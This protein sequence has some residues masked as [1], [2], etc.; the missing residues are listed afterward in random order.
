MAKLLF[1]SGKD[2][3]KASRLAAKNELHRIRQG[4]YIDTHDPAEIAKTLDNSW[5][6][7]ACNIVD[8]PIAV[9]RTAVELK[10]AG[11]RL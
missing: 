2:A 10:P 5:M 8:E 3:K 9:A 4:V 6:E 1:P 7:V 11:N